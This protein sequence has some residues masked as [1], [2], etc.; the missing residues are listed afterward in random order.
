MR[1]RSKSETNA[2]LFGSQSVSLSASPV[3]AARRQS[4]MAMR[5]SLLALRA[6]FPCVLCERLEVPL[7]SS[8]GATTISTLCA[9]CDCRLDGSAP[10]GAWHQ[11]VPTFA[12]LRDLRLHLQR[13]HAVALGLSPSAASAARTE[14][15]PLQA[16]VRRASVVNRR[17]GLLRNLDRRALAVVRDAADPRAIAA[18][19]AAPVG[20][21]GPRRRRTCTSQAS[22]D[23]VSA[24]ARLYARIAVG[25][26]PVAASDAAAA[27]RGESALSNGSHES[28]AS[29]V[30]VDLANQVDVFDHLEECDPG[31]EAF[32][33]RR[34]VFIV[35]REP[36]ADPACLTRSRFVRNVQRRGRLFVHRCRR[37][38]ESGDVAMAD[39]AV[40]VAT[41][42]A[43][44][45]REVDAHPAPLLVP[46]TT[47]LPPP[48]SP[49]PWFVVGNDL[50]HRRALQDIIGRD[51]VVGVHAFENTATHWRSELRKVI[52][53][54]PCAC[55]IVRATVAAKVSAE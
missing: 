28:G 31:A 41:E 42:M 20:F 53:C 35:V 40:R 15:K 43:L 9:R 4:L 51:R 30:F 17:S 3:L 13:A 23:G 2:R 14:P 21:G 47:T 44:L 45:E 46:A 24:L 16:I 49:P 6:R 19:A 37:D 33:R 29:L 48:L 32:L 52:A 36:R 22:G 10:H 12:R 8:T 18:D 7:S 55:G 25:H 11:P 38:R 39:I 5:A 27:L 50:R 1:V 26:V 34:A 54:L